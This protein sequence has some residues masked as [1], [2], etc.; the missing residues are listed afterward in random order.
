MLHYVILI[1]RQS[2]VLMFEAKL[3]DALPDIK[4]ELLSGMVLALLEFSK[5]LQIGE[6]STFKTHNQKFM[7]SVTSNTLVALIIDFKDSEK[8]FELLA[9][10]IGKRFEDTFDIDKWDG[11]IEYFEPFSEVLQTIINN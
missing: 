8:E 6:L 1:Q 9:V 2:G 5:E 7:I 3:S 11:L 10:E 4:S